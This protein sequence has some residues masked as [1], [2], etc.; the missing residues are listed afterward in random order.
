M[1]YNAKLD[2]AWVDKSS[3]GGTGTSNLID[4]G[5][6]NRWESNQLDAH[7]RLTALEAGGGGGSGITGLINVKDSPYS[8]IGNGTSDD[9]AALQ[10]ALD[11]VPATGGI[12]FMP[13]GRYKVTS[14]LTITRQNV[15]LYGAGPGQRVG[16]TQNATGARIEAATTGF[17]GTAVLRVAPTSGTVPLHG[18]TLRDFAIDCQDTGTGVDGIHFRSNRSLIDHVYVF[19][20]TGA[21]IRLE[22]YATWD[23]YDSVLRNVQ[24][25]ECAA[26]GLLLAEGATDMHFEHCILFNNNDNMALTG[27][28]SCQ[29][30]GCHFYDATRYNIFFNGA[31]SRSKFCN[32]KIEGAGQ[33]GVNID[34]TVQGYSDIQIHGCNI[35][36]N[37]DSANNTYDGIIIQG[38]SG[39]GVSRTNISGCAF[40]TKSGTVNEVRYFVNISSTAAQFTLVAAN[41]FGAASQVGTG[42]VNN[43]GSGGSPT[44]IAA[45]IG[46]ADA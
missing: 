19:Q 14:T 13:A 32:C 18:V 8:A 36:N 35:T 33:H 38:P 17:S 10:A 15:T 34:S 39:N 12:V 41:T 3:A 22:G 30:T 25:S 2:G 11:A 45:N 9:T 31:G 28:G 46:V 20:A 5:D 43:A 23:L 24:V 1:A 7:T 6:C 44:R 16:A 4:A 37:G 27:G 21:G 29:V 42:I 26:E 40:T